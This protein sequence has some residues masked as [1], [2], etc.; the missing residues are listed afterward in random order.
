M[1][2]VLASARANAKRMARQ[3]HS[4]AL[5]GAEQQHLLNC[6]GSR[7]SS[8]APAIPAAGRRSCSMAEKNAS[9]FP[10]RDLDRLG[11]DPVDRRSGLTDLVE[12]RPS[13]TSR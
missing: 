9:I 1:N 8:A 7:W 3:Q 6:G 2:G 13:V 11:S 4:N 10:Q 5:R 12:V